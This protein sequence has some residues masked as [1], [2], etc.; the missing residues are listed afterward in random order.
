MSALF[1]D[2]GHFCAA[3][4]AEAQGPLVR[5]LTDSTGRPVAAV[6]AA[7]L[8]APPAAVWK[9]I[10]DLPAW[11]GRV[12]MLHKV[13]RVGDLVHVQLKFKVT[14]V[15][16][17]FAFVAQ[18]TEAP[19]RSL[20]L[21]WRS[22]EPAKIDLRLDLAPDGDGTLLEARVGF[23]ARSLGWLVKFFLRHHPEIEYGIFPGS[24]LA[25]LEAMRTTVNKLN[26][27]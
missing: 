9:V 26:V 18:V 10:V 3:A 22:G 2:Q 11:A 15:S 25:L 19:E 13:E 5:V 8:A 16:V 1:D 12:P 23:E 21:E 27:P 4:V 24:A 14:V 20:R 17:G 7:R 6:A